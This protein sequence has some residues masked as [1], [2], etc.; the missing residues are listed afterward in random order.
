MEDSIPTAQ[1]EGDADLARVEPAGLVS[2]F[3]SGFHGSGIE[4][5]LHVS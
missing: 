3:E 1:T 5:N 2:R 4:P